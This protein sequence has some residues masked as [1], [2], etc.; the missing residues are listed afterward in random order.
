MYATSCPNCP[1]S[2]QTLDQA[3]PVVGVEAQEVSALQTP[4]RIAGLATAVRRHRCPT[5][6]DGLLVSVAV[7]I[8]RRRW[9]LGEV[10][11]DPLAAS[12]PQQWRVRSGLGSRSRRVELALDP[13]LPDLLSCWGP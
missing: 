5:K 12:L 1:K 10:L 11:G 8:V 7:Q 9:G 6:G 4:M 3:Q 13:R 2:Q